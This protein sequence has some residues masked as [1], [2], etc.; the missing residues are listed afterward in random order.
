MRA[1]A[2]SIFVLLLCACSFHHQKVVVVREAPAPVVEQ[3][4]DPA[5]RP[6]TEA[7]R[8]GDEIVVCGR[9][10]H[11]GTPVVLWT[12]PDGYDAYRVWRRFSPTDTRPTNPEAGCDTANRYGVRPVDG[13]PEPDRERVRAGGWDLP[14]LAQ[15][16]DKF[17]I[18]YD[19]CGASR[20]C[21]RILHDV[22]GLSV[23]FL[24][25]VDGT[26]YQTLDL[27]ERA[28]HSGPA[29]DQ[30]V[31]V[32]IAQIG[33]YDPDDPKEKAVLDAWYKADE[34]GRLRVRLPAHL[35]DPHLR[36]KGFVPRPAREEPV[37]GRIHG[38][39]LMQFDFTEEQYRSLIQL[40]ATLCTV[41]PKIRSDAPRDADGVV[42][43]SALSAE[44]LAKFGGLVGH[45][46][47]TANKIDPGP[48]F[49]WERVLSGAR[50]AMTEKTSSP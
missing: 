17:V 16:V 27:K 42:R 36:V 39:N 26:I 31:G 2:A 21:F 45:F 40:S 30:S 29:N 23:H 49:D 50:S 22:R 8:T 32:E 6:G 14:A 48:A 10:F 35:G 24:L 11:T 15:V 47:L 34:T 19:V 44:E 41:L 4:V 7:A 38:R 5:P 37:V 20:Q 43:T 18:H 12:D 46:H 3:K 28:R 9:M 25:D 1:R 33:A 13:L